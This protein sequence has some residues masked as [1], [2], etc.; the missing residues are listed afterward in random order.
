MKTQ[1]ECQRQQEIVLDQAT[2]YRRVRAESEMCLV[3]DVIA[4]MRGL[5][6]LSGVKNGVGSKAQAVMCCIAQP[7]NA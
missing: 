1:P 2:A 5:F 6:V 3:G 7:I 4:D